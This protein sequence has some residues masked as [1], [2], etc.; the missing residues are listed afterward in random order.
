MAW[1]AAAARSDVP[2]PR[3][4]GAKTAVLGPSAPAAARANAR[5]VAALT[6]NPGCARRRVIDAAAVRPHELAEKLGMDPLDFRLL[7]GV[8]E[9]DRR[10]AG[11]AELVSRRNRRRT[12]LT[13][14]VACLLHQMFQFFGGRFSRE[15]AGSPAAAAP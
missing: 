6:G 12:L 4:S 5:S 9:G 1:T 2:R 11:A 7:T 15:R 3:K 8:R 14:V 10:A 13:N